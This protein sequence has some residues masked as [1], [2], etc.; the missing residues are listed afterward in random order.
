MDERWIEWIEPFGPNNE[1]V[2]MR[3]PAS[4]AIAVAKKNWNTPGHVYY[5]NDQDALD[6][7]MV[8]N[9]ASFVDYLGIA[10]VYHHGTRSYYRARLLKKLRAEDMEEPYDA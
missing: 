10:D 9:W 4:T 5:E 8:V 6:D 1:P 2:Y 7:F 3:V